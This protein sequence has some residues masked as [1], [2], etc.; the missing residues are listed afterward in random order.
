[1]ETEKK[2][3]MG[4]ETKQETEKKMKKLVLMRHGQTMFN[5]KKRIQ[6]WCDAP[7]TELGKA[8][9][10]NAKQYVDQLGLNFDYACSSTSERACDTLELVTDMPY[11]RLKGLKEMNF[12]K[13]EGEPEYLNPPLAEYSAFFKA[14]GGETREEAGERVRKTLQEVMSDPNHNTVFAVSHG[15]AMKN[16]ARTCRLGPNVDMKERFYNCCVMVLEYDPQTQEF[17]W[18]D[19]FNENYTGK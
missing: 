15:A 13:F 8:Q 14:A 2:P 9:A 5:E 12:G 4:T 7:L 6:G 11:T 17:T 19:L 18:T 1:M 3:E 10:R 16:F